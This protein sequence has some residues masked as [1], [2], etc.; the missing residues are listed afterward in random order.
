MA[1]GKNQAPPFGK[2]G[3]GGKGGKPG[4]PVSKGMSKGGR[5]SKGC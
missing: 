1:F 3:K 2:G 4:K 5:M